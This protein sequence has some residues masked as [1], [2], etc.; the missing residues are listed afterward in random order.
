VVHKPV[1][2]YPPERW[3]EPATALGPQ[4]DGL[5]RSLTDEIHLRRDSEEFQFNA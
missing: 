4:H 2:L 3:R 1:W 5:R